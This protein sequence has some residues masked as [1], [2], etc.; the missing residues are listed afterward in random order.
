MKA[1][2]DSSDARSAGSRLFQ[3]I[4][5]HA[6][7]WRLGPDFLTKRAFGWLL[8]NCGPDNATAMTTLPN[9]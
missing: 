7:Q 5:G 2:C 9:C 3:I 8:L 6:M 4:I 1:F